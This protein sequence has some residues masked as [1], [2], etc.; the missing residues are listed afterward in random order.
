MLLLLTTENSRRIAAVAGIGLAMSLPS[1]AACNIVNGKAY[2]DCQGITVRQGSKAALNVR[3][4]VTEGAI[5]AGA[6]VYFGGSLY[7]SG[8]SGGD[9]IVKKGGR[10]LVSGIVNGTVR[11]DGGIVEIEGIIE[12]LVSNGGSAVVGGQV[13]GVSG[14]GPVIF[15]KG[16]V[17][18][19][20]PLE[21]ELRFPVASTAGGSL[22]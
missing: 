15:K 17:L 21:R 13:G 12:H 16:S 11:N 14:E 10:L 19:G 4:Y 6:T 8:I 22:R 1:W 2:G 5:V 7:L 20:N 3:S 9:I 18:Q